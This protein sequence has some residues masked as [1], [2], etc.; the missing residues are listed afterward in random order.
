MT[1]VA[2]STHLLDVG[3]SLGS[4]SCLSLGVTAAL[5]AF[6]VRPLSV[7]SMGHRRHGNV[8]T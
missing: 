3:F 5:R 2:L 4:M 1:G 8:I 6:R 7:W